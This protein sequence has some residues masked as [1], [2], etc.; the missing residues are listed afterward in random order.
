MCTEAGSSRVMQSSFKVAV[1]ISIL[2]HCSGLAL[3]AWWLGKVAGP[4][5]PDSGKAHALELVVVRSPAPKGLPETEKLTKSAP[6]PE[7]VKESLDSSLLPRASAEA[8]VKNLPKPKPTSPVQA[9]AS[10]LSHYIK[11]NP[12]ENTTPE[13][14]TARSSVAENAVTGS[15]VEP[16]VSKAEPRPTLRKKAGIVSRRGRGSADSNA[17]EP[18]SSAGP[19]GSIAGDHRQ[20]PAYLYHPPPPYPV[21]ARQRSYQ[22]RVELLAEVLPNGNVGRIKV[23]QSSGFKIL[24]RAALRAAKSWRFQPSRSGDGTYLSW[25]KIPI[26]FSLV[27]ATE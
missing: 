10:P 3:A 24:D 14:E 4:V 18:T 26:E 11:H 17:D 12:S 13:Q 20:E 25:V 27:E 9:V 19:T 15:A 6:S 21:L 22:G 1:G 8:T 2:A 5:F 23:S 16:V 7:L